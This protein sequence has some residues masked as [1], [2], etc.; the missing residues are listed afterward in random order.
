MTEVTKTEALQA[1]SGRSDL[2]FDVADLCV[3]IGETSILH[4]IDLQLRKG[5]CLGVVG[6]SGSGKS[7]TAKA[8]AGLLPTGSVVR[9]NYRIDADE[10]RLDAGESAWRRLRGGRVVWL[11]QDPFTSLDPRRRCGE[12]ILDGLP[13]EQRPSADQRHAEAARRLKEVGLPERVVR[14]YPH[15]LSGGMRQ[16]VAIAAALAPGPKI[17]IADEPTTALDVTTQAG[18]LD[19]L[20]EVRANH[21]MSMVLITH[22]LFL[23]REY[24]DDLA[25][26]QSGRVVEAGPAE[27]VF[28]NPRDEVTKQL[29]EIGLSG[30]RLHSNGEA[31]RLVLAARGITKTYPGSEVP[32]IEDA[33][34]DLRA[35]E[36]VGVVGESGSGKTTF[37]RCL[38]TLEHPDGGRYGYL[39]E[40]GEP[41]PWAPQ[42]AQ[43]VFQNPYASL[44]PAKTIGAT[45]VEALRSAGRPACVVPQLLELVGL[46]PA[47]ATRRPARLSGG[48]RQRVAIARALAPQPTVL[49][50]DEAVSA[51][52]APVQAKI[53]ETLADLRDKLG[54]AIVFITHDLTVV[55]RIADR[56]YVMQSGQVV[57]SGP[58]RKVFAEPEH[59]YTRELLASVPGME[60]GSMDHDEEN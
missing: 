26:F 37:T 42:R 48:E 40:Q 30:R 33:G 13:R 43:L 46:D 51:L 47:L 12:Q 10:C 11:P 56:V 28:N 32:A 58:T 31:G 19:L 23:A 24:C 7:M 21:H 9:G 22:D 20:A 60:A 55:A 29:V 8:L 14:A 49:F 27:E 36:I 4:G 15:E 54:L 34:L 2:A 53:L 16:R 41:Q 17:L 59:P 45:L 25:V 6:Q 57:E 52:D 18:I 38:L 44:N 5:T 39:D 35:G 3:D 1:D 50:C